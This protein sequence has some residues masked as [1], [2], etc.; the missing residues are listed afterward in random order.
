MGFAG[1][2]LLLIEKD[3]ALRLMIEQH[4]RRGGLCEVEATDEA[5]SGLERAELGQYDIVMVSL[6]L[7]GLPPARLLTAL[8]AIRPAPLILAIAKPGSGKDLAPE[9]AALI[10]QTLPRPLSRPALSRAIGR[11]VV[12][13]HQR[14][15]ASLVSPPPPKDGN[16]AAPKRR[17]KPGAAG[18]RL[19]RY[20]L[21]DCLGRSDKGAVYRGLIPASGRTVAVRVFPRDFLERLGRGQWWRDWFKREVSA[22]SSVAH[23]HLAALID[24]G[25]TED[26]RCLYLVYDLIEGSSIKARIERGVLTPKEAVRM[27]FHI[28]K[29]LA[30]VHS[31]GFAHRLVRPSNI[32]VDNEGN[33]TLTDLG[34]ASVLAWDLIPLRDRLGAMPYLSPEQVRLS[35]V[36]DRADQ[37]SLGLVL[38]EALTGRSPFGGDGP[39]ARLRAILGDEPDLSLEGVAAARTELR[40]VL[41]KM[42][43]RD[44]NDRFQG[45]AELKNALKGCAESLM[46]ER[47]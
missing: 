16:G 27:A 39:R 38:H 19:G 2:R 40:E 43:A 21:R 23:P 31:V 5:Q 4:L 8:A 14:A 30:A 12:N 41:R 35:H 34:I 47:A 3:W 24:H 9:V 18:Y 46:R 20:E 10:W 13:L 25:A 17:R 22:A 6:E 44:P 26:E 15:C 7:G 37:F 33:A 11:A 42:L 29:A 28:T 36:D 32:I 45:D 1:S